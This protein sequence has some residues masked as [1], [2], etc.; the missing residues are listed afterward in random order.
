VPKLLDELIGELLGEL[1]DE[2][3]RPAWQQA[4]TG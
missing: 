3:Q 4:A 1:R 2:D